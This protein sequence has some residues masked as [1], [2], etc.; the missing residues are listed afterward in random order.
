[1]ENKTTPYGETCTAFFYA[2]QTR[3]LTNIRLISSY[4]VTVIIIHG[5]TMSMIGGYTF[6]T[7]SAIVGTVG[8]VICAGLCAAGFG[9]IA[10]IIGFNVSDVEALLFVEQ[11]TRII[12]SYSIKIEIIQGISGSLGM[13]LTIPLVAL[14]ASQLIPLKTNLFPALNCPHQKD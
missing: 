2:R 9:V 1:L 4:K 5:V 14:I 12:N 7:V 3:S 13:I 10:E 11:M 8:G 6:K